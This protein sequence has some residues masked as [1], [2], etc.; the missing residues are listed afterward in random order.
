MEY[1]K[2]HPIEYDVIITGNYFVEVTRLQNRSKVFI[3]RRWDGVFEGYAFSIS[4]S[5]GNVSTT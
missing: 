4:S 2:A 1:I 5:S 3:A